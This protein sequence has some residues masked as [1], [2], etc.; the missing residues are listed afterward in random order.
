M[1]NRSR[2]REIFEDTESWYKKNERLRNAVQA[3]IASTK[4]YE[5]GYN[6]PEERESKRFD[7]QIK[8]SRAKTFESARRLCGK[9]PEARVAVHNFAS[10]TNPGGGVRKGS[11]A[12][13]ESLC[14]CSTLY[15][16][17][18]TP[19]LMERYYRYHR[20]R[21]DVRYTDTCIYTPD[22]WIIKTDS[23]LPERMPETDWCKVDVITCAAPNLRAIP[24]NSMNPGTGKAIKMN[25]RDLLELH[26]KRARHMLQAASDQGAEILVLGAFGCGAFQNR[27]EIVA[28]AYKETLSDFKGK[29]REI[30]FAVYCTPRES[31]NFEIFQR[32]L[33]KR[34]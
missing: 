23:A 27:P 11:S 22:I 3:S 26:K 6:F 9:Y 10:A 25:D 13:E 2:L 17:L 5:E 14:R 32:V 12:Q 19:E 18:N 4:V 16:V 7:T 21:Q 33:G 31:R 8:V 1:D 24:Y 29:F 20:N 15:P 34:K 30:E 28:R